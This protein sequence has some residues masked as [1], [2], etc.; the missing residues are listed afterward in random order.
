MALLLSYPLLVHLAVWFD[1]PGLEFLALFFLIL[2][3][4]LP[5]LK[6]HRLLTWGLFLVV[7]AALCAVSYLDITIYF[8]YLPPVL[9]SLLFFSVFLHSLLPKHVPLV[10]AIGERARGPLS[11]EMRSY[12]WSVTL[13]WTVFFALMALW[14]ALLPWLASVEIWSLFT[15]FVNYI[16]VALLFTAEFMYRKWRFQEH[17]HPGFIDYFKIVANARER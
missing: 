5:G 7:L 14:S 6:R 15:N 13:I 10:T 9:I 2:R 4:L 3:L 16:L 8:L 1:L 12:T 17:D 11:A